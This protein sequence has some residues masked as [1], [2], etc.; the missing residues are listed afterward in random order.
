MT[1]QERKD[2][3]DIIAKEADIVYKKLFVL[4]VVSGAIGGFGLSIFDKAFIISLILFLPFLFLSF[5]IVLAYLKL[6]KLEMIIK[7]LRDE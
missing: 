5:G 3:A 6:N 4:M 1:F 2:K 7:D